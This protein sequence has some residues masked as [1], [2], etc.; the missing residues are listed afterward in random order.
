MLKEIIEEAKIFL[1]KIYYTESFDL[2]EL[3]K[4]NLKNVLLEKDSKKLKIKRIYINTLEK[5]I[6]AFVDIIKE[7]WLKKVQNIKNISFDTHLFNEKLPIHSLILQAIQFINPNIN[8]KEICNS[9]IVIIKDENQKILCI[10]LFGFNNITEDLFKNYQYIK[11]QRK[12]GN[13]I[14]LCNICQKECI[15]Q[16]CH[17]CH[18]CYQCYKLDECHICYEFEEYNPY[19]MYKYYYL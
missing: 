17:K 8:Y 5:S 7:E 4:Y 6:N 19:Y 10:T 9:I 14:I 15:C 3:K 13:N 11:A 12:I 2:F 1:Y 16:E 18:R